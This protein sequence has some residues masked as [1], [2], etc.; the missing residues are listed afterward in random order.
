MNFLPLDAKDKIYGDCY[1][2]IMIK[3]AFRQKKHFLVAKVQSR[4]RPLFTSN[5]DVDEDQ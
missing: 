5:L 3:Q 4:D 2:H 1:M